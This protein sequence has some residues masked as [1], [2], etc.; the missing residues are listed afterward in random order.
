ML[1]SENAYL[2]GTSVNQVFERGPLDYFNLQ[3]SLGQTGA[4]P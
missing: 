1:T 2:P 3:G 4:E